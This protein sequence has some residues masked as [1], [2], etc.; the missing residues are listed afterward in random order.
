MVK[1][2]KDEGEDK[3]DVARPSKLI[4]LDNFDSA[5]GSRLF[6]TKVNIKNAESTNANYSLSLKG[7]KKRRFL[8]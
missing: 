1:F 6:L 2:L 8:E 5:T 4:K 7:L 3:T